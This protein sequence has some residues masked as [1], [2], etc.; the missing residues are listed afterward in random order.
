MKRYGYP[1]LLVTMLVPL[2]IASAGLRQLQPV[3]IQI[4]SAN[5]I[6]GA[7][8]N[9]ADAYNSADTNQYIG[10]GGSATAGWCQAHDATPTADGTLNLAFCTT[11]DPQLIAHIRSISSDAFI[12]FSVDPATGLCRSL[13]V[14]HNSGYRP[15]AP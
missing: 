13:S 3:T 11:T 12:A 9:L 6:V 7:S 4:D 2:G 1:L 5:Q 8:G 14:S 10:C 15:K